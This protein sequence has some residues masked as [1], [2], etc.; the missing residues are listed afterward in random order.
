MAGSNFD[1]LTVCR[2]TL[3]TK[4]DENRD[5]DIHIETAIPEGFYRPAEL[6]D[7]VT[8]TDDMR[9]N[10]RITCITLVDRALVAHEV[11]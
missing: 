2:F 7:V 3:L 1:T 6:P 4:I 5:G 9:C 11:G 10:E 8:N